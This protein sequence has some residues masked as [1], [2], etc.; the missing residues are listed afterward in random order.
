MKQRYW[1][2][3]KTN[4]LSWTK[5]ENYETLEIGEKNENRIEQN[6]GQNREGKDTQNTKSIEVESKTIDRNWIKD[7]QR[8]NLLKSNKKLSWEET[9]SIGKET[10]KWSQIKTW[11][12]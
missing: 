10:I 8:R 9:K 2:A 7:D 3:V 4:E 6:Y 12:Q 11:K 5:L 1:F